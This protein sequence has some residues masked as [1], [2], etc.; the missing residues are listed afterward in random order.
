MI[1]DLESRQMLSAPPAVYWPWPDVDPAA[2]TAFSA[3]LIYKT[4]AH[5]VR[6]PFVRC[7]F[8]DMSNRETWF[9]LWTAKGKIAVKQVWHLAANTGYLSTTSQVGERVVLD[10]PYKPGYAYNVRAYIETPPAP[11][12]LVNRA[13][14]MGSWDGVFVA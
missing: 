9:Q 2:P 11:A 10:Y 6:A 13:S 7:K 3:T 5:G 1:E 14:L 4:N 8:T 12:Y